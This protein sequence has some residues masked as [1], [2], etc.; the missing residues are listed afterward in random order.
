MSPMMSKPS[1]VF[2]FRLARFD[3]VLDEEMQ[4][5]VGNDRIDDLRGELEIGLPPRAHGGRSR[6]GSRDLADWLGYRGQRTRS[7]AVRDFRRQ[8]RRASCRMWH[9]RADNA[10]HDLLAGRAEWRPES[11]ASA[12]HA[13]CDCGSGP[14]SRRRWRAVGACARVRRHRPGNS[15]QCRVRQGRARNSRC[16]PRYLHFVDNVSGDCGRPTG[17]FPHRRSVG[18]NA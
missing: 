15:R 11:P 1:R 9:R 6:A 12:A 18:G 5:P 8:N 2:L 13:G 14:G 16:L 17:A 7:A 4:H 10:V 3:A